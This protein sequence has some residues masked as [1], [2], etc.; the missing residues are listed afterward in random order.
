MAQMS[1]S[2]GD[3]TEVV[4]VVG[5]GT[6]G[7]PLAG[8]LRGAGFAVC[9][10]DV[11]DEAMEALRAAGGVPAASAAD[12]ADRSTLVF[13][14]LPSI[15]ALEGVVDGPGGLSSSSNTA[16]VVAELSTMPLATKFWVRDRLEATGMTVLDCPLS[17]TGAQMRVKDVVVYA[18]GESD[19]VARARPVFAAFGRGTYDLGEF[20]NGSRMKY[21]A[22][23]L[24][25]I[26][27]LAAAEALLLASRAGLDLDAVMAAITDG[28][29]TSRMLEVRGP[30]MVRR[31]Y[32]DATMRMRTYQKDIDI[33]GGFAR[34]LE[35]PVPLFSAS[36]AYYLAGLAE[37][38]DDQ[39]TASVFAVLE[40]LVPSR[41]GD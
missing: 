40:R 38:L 13:T 15:A 11:R 35:C 19:A 17:G 23:H 34:D 3:R 5:L 22:N 14:S 21:V 27:N 37:G 4:G 26:H 10:F 39:D 32:A 28:A 8:H 20:G 7:G 18:S 6:M 12:V 30:M 41:H 25:T 33:I 31:D 29:G 9:G 1:D 2:S 36:A 16:C 24:V